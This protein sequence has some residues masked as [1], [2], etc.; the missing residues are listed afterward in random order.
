MEWQKLN[1]LIDELAWMIPQPTSILFSVEMHDWAPMFAKAKEIQDGFNKK[2]RYPTRDEQQAAWARFSDTRNLLFERANHERKRFREESETLRN[3]ILSHVKHAGY[4]RL[5]D[6]IF[7]FTPTTV[8]EMKAAGVTLREGGQMLSRY[9]NRM[10]AEHKN[11]CFRRIQEL[12]AS[13]DVF[14]G[15]YKAQS[16]E[17]RAA[18]KQRRSEIAQ[19]IEANIRAN[20]EKLAKAQA[21][22][23]RVQANIAENEDRLANA[24]GEAFAERVSGWISEAR[25][26]LESIDESITRINQW[27]AEEESR[28]SDLYARDR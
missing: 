21:A 3:E 12:R 13:H 5:T 8:E 15:Q 2:V 10:L 7:V 4:D 22:Y 9:K 23:D 17:R 18:S 6:L 24:R 20:R 1:S 16:V 14:W 26:K 19:K 11:E 27:I 25:Q 28:L